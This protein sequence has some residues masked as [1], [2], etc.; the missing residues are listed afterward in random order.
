M[1]SENVGVDRRDNPG[2]DLLQKGGMSGYVARAWESITLWAMMLLLWMLR[3]WQG[4][5]ARANVG[6]FESL[7]LDFRRYDFGIFESKRIVGR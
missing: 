5:M 3:C 4:A 6:D 7:G 1:D 2:V